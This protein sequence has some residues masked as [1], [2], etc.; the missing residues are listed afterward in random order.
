MYDYHSKIN[1][2]IKNQ[3]ITLLWNDQNIDLCNLFF[4]NLLDVS[5]LSYSKDDVLLTNYTKLL[6]FFS[7][8]KELTA[9]NEKSDFRNIEI[10]KG[11]LIKSFAY[12]FRKFFYFITH[13]E[14]SQ[15]NRKFS[16][17]Q[18]TNQEI[19]IMAKIKKYAKKHSN[20]DN[21]IIV[22]NNINYSNQIDIL[23]F[24]KIIE[25]NF[26]NLNAKNLKF[27]F[28]SS[29]EKVLD[30]QLN[31]IKRN[32]L[33]K[34]SLEENELCQYIKNSY[35]DL[36]IDDNKL[37]QYLK[38]CNNDFSLINSIITNNQNQEN[39]EIVDSDFKHIQKIIFNILESRPKLT[40]LEIAA[41]IG[42]TFDIT[43]LKN[44]SEVPI[45]DLVNRL[46]DA[47]SLGFL[48][49]DDYKYNY[50]FISD[51]I[52]DIIYNHGSQ[53]SLWHKKYAEEINEIS[54]NEHALI[55]YHYL[56]GNDFKSAI[57]QYWACM[58]TSVIDDKNITQEDK[59]NLE[60]KNIINNN[61]IW[62]SNYNYLNDLLISYTKGKL[63]KSRLVDNYENQMNAEI[64]EI[65]KYTKLTLLYIG[66]YT[67]SE[68]EFDNLS[69]ELEKSY[70]FLKEKHLLGLQIRCGLYLID[71]LSYRLNKN[72]KAKRMQIELEK[73]TQK[74]LYNLSMNS[75]ILDNKSLVLKIIRKTSMLSN[76]EIAY[77]KT[78]NL[79]YACSE[80]KESLDEVELY[81]FLSDHIG[82]ALYS[83]YFPNVAQ[84]V[85]DELKDKMVLG[86]SLNFPKQYKLRMN[87]FLYRLFNEQLSISDV[88][89]FLKEEKKNKGISSSMYNYDIAAISLYCSKLDEAENILLHLYKELESNNTCFYHYCYNS[90]LASLYILKKDYEKAKYY[91]DLILNSNFDWFEDFIHIMKFRAEKFEEFI[92]SKKEFTPKKLYNCFSSIPFRFSNT[93][94]FLGKG[95]LFSELMF[96]RE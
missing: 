48:T 88:K 16:N 27:V 57:Y 33:L 39:T 65:I 49:Q 81:K 83:G 54:P 41:V 31:E 47:Y 44:I 73:I 56:L 37:K 4:T 28:I 12:L 10:S 62:K 23:F 15:I 95:I 92:E 75:N 36:H 22:I 71:I 63:N 32:N 5:I 2:M 17:Y 91:N 70:L 52:K 60:I 50:E 13:K 77:E 46:S 68:S 3:Q 84:D 79:L 66:R 9:F 76:A 8:N 7:A 34:V 96:Y 51:F 40:V 55:S 21:H 1:K 86:N 85:I 6:S 18:F 78:K 19:N 53:Q 59:L 45:D 93:W 43:I 90:N 26:L 74:I 38:L 69:D 61:I 87:Y 25:S 58:L 67:T 72:E 14:Y 24:K 20:N 89:S 64:G 11:W 80:V 82:Y 42:L 94:K 35:K 29:S 30:I